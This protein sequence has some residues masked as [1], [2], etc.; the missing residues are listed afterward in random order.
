MNKTP[1]A[2]LKGSIFSLKGRL[3]GS[4][5]NQ[6]DEAIKSLLDRGQVHIL[7]DMEQLEYISSAGLKLLLSTLKKVRKRKGN[8][9]LFN[10]TGHVREVFEFAGLLDVIPAAASREEARKMLKHR[11]HT[12]VDRPGP[13]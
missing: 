4:S 9:V 13:M 7:V 10:L 5:V 3:D 8:L 1:K 11:S 12:A 2:P 6:A